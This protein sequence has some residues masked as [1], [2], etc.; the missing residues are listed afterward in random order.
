MADQLT[1]RE[2]LNDWQR[3]SPCRMYHSFG[4]TWQE[5]SG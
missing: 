2:R 4:N 1:Y 3:F 5:P